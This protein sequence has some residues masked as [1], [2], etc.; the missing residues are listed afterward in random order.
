MSQQ[1]KEINDWK[2]I[3]EKVKNQPDTASNGKDPYAGTYSNKLYGTISITKAIANGYLIKFNSHPD[4]TATLQ[5]LGGGED[6]LLEYNNIE[7]GVFKTKFK[8][9]NGKVISIDI[10]A[11]D[12]VEYD[13]YTFIKN[14]SSK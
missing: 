6:W 5:S 14:A 12:F 4:L 1:V 11:N 3:V 7:F 8:I 13:V 2:M 10:K 9:V